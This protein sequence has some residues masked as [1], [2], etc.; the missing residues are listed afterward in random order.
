MRK[1]NKRTKENRQ[2]IEKRLYSQND[3]IRLLKET[4]NAK[5]IESVEAHISL[6][7]D[8][9]YS[10]QQL[11]STLILPKGTGNTK[12][13]AVLMPLESITPEYKELADIIGSDDLIEIITKGDIN[14]DILIA[15][16]D[17]MPKLA[18]LGRILGPKGLMPSPK[19]GTVTTDVKLTLEEFKKGKL[20]YRA[21]KTGIVHLLIGKSNFPDS[22]LLENLVAVYTSIENNKPPG[23]KGRYF[24]TFHICSTMGPSIEID[25]SALKL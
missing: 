25:I 12:R 10:D 16:P 5:F 8:P 11:R 3:A 21:D 9:K 2:K 20:E 15:T 4:A 6:S 18:K 7:I 23:V 1:L 14:F 13:I 17:M 22:D 19:A 24:K